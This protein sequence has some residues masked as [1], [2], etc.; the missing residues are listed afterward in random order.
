MADTRNPNAVKVLAA[1][2]KIVDSGYREG[3]NND[4]IMGKWFGLNHQPWCA[5][6]VSYCFNE[7]G[8]VNLVAAQSPKGFASCNAGL[9]WFAKNGQ[10]VPIAQAQPGDIAFFNFDS[11][12]TTAEHVG[13]I[14]ANDPVKHTLTTFE[15]NTSGDVKGSQANGDGAF[16]KT[17]NYGL[18]MAVARPKW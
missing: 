11:D 4:T 7:A 14:Y 13:L 2:K 1:A 15:G 12:P 16:K 9:K 8:L 3:E 10:I 6:F 17:R 18:I 5:M